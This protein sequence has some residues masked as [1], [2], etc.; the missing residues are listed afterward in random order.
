MRG[1]FHVRCCIRTCESIINTHDGGVGC[2][3]TYLYTLVRTVLEAD[4]SVSTCIPE[5]TYTKRHVPFGLIIEH[6]S[7]E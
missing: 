2:Y 3:S 7:A 1:N 4:R 5:F 6:L